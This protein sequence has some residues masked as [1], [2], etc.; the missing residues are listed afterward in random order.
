M[1]ARSICII[2]PCFNEADRL[3]VDRYREFTAMH[4]GIHFLFVNDGSR[5]QT[6]SVLDQLSAS[7][8]ERLRVLHLA[9]NRGKAE[10]IRSGANSMMSWK[11][12]SLAGY[13]DADLSAPP[14]AILELEQELERRPQSDLALGSRVALLGRTIRRN[15]RR[16]YL[17]RV[18]AT[19]VSLMLQLPVYDTQCGAKLFRTGLIPEIFAEP[20]V[21]RWFF[22]VEIIYRIL[23]ARGRAA[24]AAA[25]VE[26]PLSTWIDYGGSK[27]RLADFVR[28]PIELWR[29]RQHYG[30]VA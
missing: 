23:R 26:V 12:F 10:A 15:M 2:V 25:I 18:F 5:D 6:K 28:T 29:I 7:M 1:P 14:E 20:F 27:L 21:T 17:G 3:A 4:D 22:D 9:D 30:R 11:E 24:G 13:L 8:P 19:A 16:H